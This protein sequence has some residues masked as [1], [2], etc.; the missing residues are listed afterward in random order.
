MT[1]LA[2]I[3]VT[4]LGWWCVVS[5][6]FGGVYMLVMWLTPTTLATWRPPR[7]DYPVYELD[8]PIGDIMARFREVPPPLEGASHEA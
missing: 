5:F 2:E 3:I 4:M 6:C 7:L 1:R 8:I